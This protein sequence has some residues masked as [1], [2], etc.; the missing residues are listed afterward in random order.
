MSGTPEEVEDQHTGQP[1]TGNPLAADLMDM[2]S[3]N[4]HVIAEENADNAAESGKQ[5]E[6]AAHAAGSSDTPTDYKGR[7]FDPALHEVDSDGKPVIGDRNRLR[8]KKGAQAKPT[9]RAAAKPAAKIPPKIVI[10]N[11]DGT[12][13]AAQVDAPGSPAAQAALAANPCDPAQ[14]LASAQVCMQLVTTLGKMIDSDEWEPKP[15]EKQN[16]TSAFQNYFMVRGSPDIPPEVLV[17]ATVGAYAV[18]RLQMP[19]TSDK[20]ARVKEALILRFRAAQA[21]RAVEDSGHG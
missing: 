21:A 10:P 9:P 17:I 4:D 16:L 6:P 3:V 11:A 5:A 20:I 2:P 19:R 7:A 18:P 12:P 15:D 1:D 8:I 14:A 13:G